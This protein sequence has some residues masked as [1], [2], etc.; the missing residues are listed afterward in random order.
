MLRRIIIFEDQGHQ[1][2][3]PLACLRPVFHLR[4]GAYS[5]ADRLKALAPKAKFEFWVLSERR[6]VLAA[7]GRGIPADIRAVGSGKTALV[8]GRAVLPWGVWQR[9]SQTPPNVVFVHRNQ[10]V[11][12]VIQDVLLH[13]LASDQPDEAAIQS[14]IHLCKKVELKEGLAEHPWD[15]VNLNGRM[16][17]DDATCFQDGGKK[18]VPGVFLIGKRSN[19]KMVR[20]AMVEPGVVLD[21]RSGPI[22]I[23]SGALVRGPGRIEGPC[24]IGPDCLVDGARLRPGVS[25]GRCCRASGEVE[26][27]VIMDFSNKHHDGFLGHSYVGSWVNLGA[28]TCNSDL[29]NNYSS[30]S[31]WTGGRMTDTGSI[32]VGCFIGDHVKTAIGTLIN[33]GAVIGP[34]C[35]VF[36]GAVRKMLPPFS[37]G[38][39][40]SFREH[41]LDKMLETATAAMSRR[42]QRLSPEMAAA[43]RGLFRETAGMRARAGKGGSA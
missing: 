37:W 11:A 16:I 21:T 42:R 38:S 33:T 35:N 27:S 24:Y 14:L 20:N 40:E 8:N 26:E 1:D 5:L 18:P 29:K 10:L 3:Y 34:G 39:S 30:V 4:C 12:A 7:A 32:K 2:L 43:I 31:V 23:D 25:L 28:Q 41:S 13:S 17:E 15:L 19:L 6:T 36:G 9:I 22:I